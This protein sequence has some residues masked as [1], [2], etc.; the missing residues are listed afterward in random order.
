MTRRQAL[1]VLLAS[2]GAFFVFG[3]LPAARLWPEGF[4]WQ[5]PHPAF[6]HMIAAIYATLG[7]F[8]LLA[9][10]Q[11]ERY[12]PIIDFTIV[13]S[14]AHGG[15]MALHVLSTPEN[16]LHWFTDIPALFALAGALWVM[17]P[18]DAHASNA[19]DHRRFTGQ[20]PA[21]GETATNLSG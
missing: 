1:R 9:A 21:V 14:F 16:R 20:Q 7:V 17:R 3:L 13:S 6:E 18:G 11:P 8:L 19:T 10:R 4:G 2:A 15:V 5:P 12:R